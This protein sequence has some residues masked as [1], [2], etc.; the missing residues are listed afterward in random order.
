MEGAG[1]TWIDPIGRW[2]SDAGRNVVLN[3]QVI[4]L[5]SPSELRQEVPT[6][7]AVRLIRNPDPSAN[8]SPI[9]RRL[10]CAVRGHCGHPES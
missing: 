7:C 4:L 3:F 10:P 5:S 2:E 8:P 9:M 1:T 6:N